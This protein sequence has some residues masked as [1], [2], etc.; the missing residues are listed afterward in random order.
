MDYMRARAPRKY[1]QMIRDP[2]A[3]DK[4]VKTQENFAEA[5]QDA[6]DSGKVAL[7][8]GDSFMTRL[9]KREKVDK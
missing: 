1:E 6:I 9:E 2:L 7:I 3:Y 4:Y 5:V 8:R